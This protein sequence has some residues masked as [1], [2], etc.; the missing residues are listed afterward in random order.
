M[1]KKAIIPFA[2]SITLVLV[3]LL[4]VDLKEIF[5]QVVSFGILPFIVACAIFSIT[6]LIHGLKWQLV[7]SHF[8]PISAKNATLILVIGYFA[9]NI[10]PARIGE[11]A[12]AMVLSKKIGIGKGIA[13]STVIVDRITDV[14]AL[15]L[16]FF[17][18]LLFT[19]KISQSIT[20]AAI[21]L[22]AFFLVILA[23]L[24]ANKKIYS[25]FR[26]LFSFLPLS[27]KKF[28]NDLPEAVESLKAENS[29]KIWLL[30]IALWLSHVPF[31]YFVL[32]SFGIK[33]GV[34]DVLVISS[35]LSLS[36]LIPSAPAYIGTFE[37]GSVLA[38]GLFGISINTAIS[39]AIIAHLAG[40]I[41][42][43][44]LGIAALNILSLDLSSLSISNDRIGS[45]E[46]S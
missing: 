16:L 22:L 38:L 17:F 12:R 26:P 18:A 23:S 40:Y 28:L 30:S 44:I 27:L 9:N 35:M 41:T 14:I 45:G 24:A 37:A 5:S 2:I 13:I 29:P 21:I 10:F 15:L 42:T 1:D 43:T 11:I 3:I 36:A 46:T 31:Y 19:T 20:I 7:I 25:L 39:F 32:D 8:R 34:F 4:L 33:L 6:Y